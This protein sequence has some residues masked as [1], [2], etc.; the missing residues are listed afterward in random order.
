[1]CKILAFLTALAISTLVAHAED[2]PAKPIRLIVTLGPGGPSDIVGRIVAAGLA[3]ALGVPVIVENRTGADGTLGMQYVLGSNPDGY[4]LGELN[5]SAGV[6]GTE[7]RLEPPYDTVGDMTMIGCMARFQMFLI[8]PA[9]SPIRTVAEFVALSRSNPGGLNWAS[10]S[11]VVHVAGQYF[12]KQNGIIAT[13][14][15]FDKGGE[16][17]VVNAVVAHTVD[18][19]FVHGPTI[20]GYRGT[21][22]K[23]RILAVMD[24]TRS[25]FFPEV[26]TVDEIGGAK[27]ALPSVAALS[28][29]RGMSEAVV[30]KLNN[31]LKVVLT[32]PETVRQL[33][34]SGASPWVCSGDELREWVVDTRKIVRELIAEGKLE[35]H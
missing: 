7:L 30:S 31:A 17:Q 12:N 4:T 16:P 23:I 14:V 10:G 33:G 21:N 2:Y 1:M 25:P 34:R 9:T 19:G 26:P 27:M 32:D 22:D 29:P 35:R 13:R 28:G 8:V 20:L 11:A 6:T 24:R 3:N 18:Y 5:N 15:P